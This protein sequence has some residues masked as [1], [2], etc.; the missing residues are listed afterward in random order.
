MAAGEIVDCGL[1]VEVY[2]TDDKLAKTSIFFFTW[3]RG[4]L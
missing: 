2:F 4:L 1:S 3:L